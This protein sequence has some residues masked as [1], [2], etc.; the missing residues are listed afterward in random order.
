M[1]FPAIELVHPMPVHQYSSSQAVVEEFEPAQPFETD[2]VKGGKEGGTEGGKL[3]IGPPNKLR[4]GHFHGNV[5]TG[6]KKQSTKGNC[7]Q[8]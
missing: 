5:C 1:S 7:T 8:K 4:G 6:V 3:K 2:P